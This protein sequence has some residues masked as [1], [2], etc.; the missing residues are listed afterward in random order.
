MNSALKELDQVKELYVK[1]CSEK[2]LLEEKMKGENETV[3]ST[4]IQEVRVHS[5]GHKW[6]GHLLKVKKNSYCWRRETLL[7][8][9]KQ[10][11]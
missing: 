10:N 2:D 11:F 5:G 6:K 7:R 4:K 9:E 8:N 3:M 1:V